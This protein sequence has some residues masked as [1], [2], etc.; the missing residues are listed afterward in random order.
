MIA[1]R[2]TRLGRQEA[3]QTPGDL[4]SAGFT[5]IELLVVI[6]IV[7]VLVA[8]TLAVGQGVIQS[9]RA[10]LAQDRIRVID[11]SIDAFTRDVSS[12][13][14]VLV[15][16]PNPDPSLASSLDDN[17]LL[18]F[19]DALDATNGVGTQ[20]WVNTSGLL[21][22]TL[23][24]AGLGDLLLPLQGEAVRFYDPEL[25]GEN[26]QPELRSIFDPWG[27]P[28][29]VVHPRMDGVI[30]SS[31]ASTAGDLGGAV[32][33]FDDQLIADTDLP[34]G[35]EATNFADI[36]VV[37]IQQIRR[38]RMTDADRGVSNEIG[39]SDGGICPGGRPYAYSIGPDNDAS[40]IDDNAYTLEPAFS[41]D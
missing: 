39:D 8:I 7:G 21:V 9:Q 26:S 12:T 16:T 29:R 18:P 15:E 14:P 38:N 4:G 11:S 6:T 24:E 23:D 40:T 25:A 41:A 20:R 17:I 10:R 3:H 30:R 32:D 36:S 35:F 37:P 22:R 13:L 28:I 5:L 33:L 19:A 1:H 34:S 27:N 2:P 31:P